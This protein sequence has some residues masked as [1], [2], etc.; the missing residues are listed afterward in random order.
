MRNT[1][2]FGLI[3]AV[4]CLTGSIFASSASASLFL[5]HPTSKLLVLEVTHQLFSFSLGTLTCTKVSADPTTPVPALRSLSITIALRYENC[6]IFGLPAHVTT[7]RW[8]FSA[9]NGLVRLLNIFTIR[10]LAENCTVFVLPGNN[11]SLQTVK[12]STIQKELRIEA[13]ITNLS[14]EGFE[15]PCSAIGSKVTYT[16]TIL[17]A[18]EGG[19]LRWHP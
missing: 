12:Y 14:V 16:G 1:R 7:S 10:L 8:L 4:V 13:N 11:Q 19:G 6:S 5:A 18:L 3:S 2:L 15:P 17:V 9:D